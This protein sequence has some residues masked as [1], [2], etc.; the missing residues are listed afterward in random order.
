MM[1]RDAW[2]PTSIIPERPLPA[3]ADLLQGTRKNRHLI[4]HKRCPNL[5]LLD[6][7]TEGPFDDE[8]IKRC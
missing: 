7:L 3:H 8:Q 5:G 2:T 4:P 1:E 6:H